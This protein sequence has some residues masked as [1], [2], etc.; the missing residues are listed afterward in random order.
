MKTTINITRYYRLAVMLP[1]LIIFLGYVIYEIGCLIFGEEYKSE[2]LTNDVFVFY[3][4]VVIIGHALFVCFL[5]LPI[6]FN[7]HIKI[8]TSR[9]LSFLSWFLSPAI[10][11]LYMWIKHFHY[12][13]GNSYI[14]DGES[15]FIFSNTIPYTIGLIW[16]FIRFRKEVKRK[17]ADQKIQF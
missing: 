8:R 14:P 17:I 11:F 7:D 4:L 3:T 2:W 15:A 10:W 6:L 13:S 12:L 16:T 5:S 1:G 9:L